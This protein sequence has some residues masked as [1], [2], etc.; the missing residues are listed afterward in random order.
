MGFINI[1]TY[2]YM[3]LIT[4]AKSVGAIFPDEDIYLIER[5]KL[6]PLHVSYTL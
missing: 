3:C 6:L 4:E 1:Y 5:V 2:T